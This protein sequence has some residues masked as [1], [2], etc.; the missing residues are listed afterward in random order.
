MAAQFSI[1]QPL[2]HAPD[3]TH[4]LVTCKRCGDA[5]LCWCKSR[6]TGR[7][8]LA[9]VQQTGQRMLRYYALAATPHRCTEPL[10]ERQMMALAARAR[11]AGPAARLRAEGERDACYELG[12]ILHEQGGNPS[13][14]HARL[15]GW[16]AQGTPRGIDDYTDG[17]ADL[18]DDVAAILKQS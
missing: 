12:D 4:R 11:F 5:R 10:T 7:G 14:V 13:V 1:S 15:L 18:R 2:N 16:L 9:D 6:R 3:V 17:R 8:Y